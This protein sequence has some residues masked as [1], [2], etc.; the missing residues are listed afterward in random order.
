MSSISNIAVYD[1]ASTPVLHTLLPIDV[2][3]TK[4]EVVANY[5]ENREDVPV[6]AQVRATLKLTR[7]KSGIFRAESRSV[8]PVM[9]SISGQNAAGYTAPPKVA[10]EDTVV[11]T[12]Y[13]HER[14]TTHGRR[15]ARQLAV[16]M[17]GG[18]TA[19]VKPVETGPI[20]ELFD[21]LV[22]PT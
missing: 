2:S 4:D 18:V 21:L 8:V 16:N 9:E 14:S 19:S 5:R 17:A 20:A 10:H 22:S 11:I 3:R 12:G 6:Y 15:L 1:G 13:F 7:L